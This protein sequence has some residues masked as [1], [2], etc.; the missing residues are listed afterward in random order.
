MQ[1]CMAI[2]S[3]KY[4]TRDSSFS[5]YEQ[6]G[7]LGR[8]DAGVTENRVPHLCLLLE[9][10]MFKAWVPTLVPGSTSPHNFTGHLWVPLHSAQF[11]STTLWC[12]I[13]ITTARVLPGVHLGNENRIKSWGF[14]LVSIQSRLEYAGAEGGM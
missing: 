4:L 10:N 3:I 2:Q 6:L 14:R 9:Y 13:R 1:T 11:Q 8:L 12:F 5:L 7:N